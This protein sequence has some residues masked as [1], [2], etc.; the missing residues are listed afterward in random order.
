MRHCLR[1]LQQGRR[2]SALVSE[3][4]WQSECGLIVARDAVDS[5]LD[6]NKAEL[7]VL[8]VSVALQVLSDGHGLLNQMIQ[9]LRQSG[10][11]SCTVVEAYG[12][13][14]GEEVKSETR[15]K[16]GHTTGRA[17]SQHTLPMR[18]RIPIPPETRALTVLLQ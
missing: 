11:K 13:R 8:V 10:S 16:R 12:W 14:E 9:I 5:R 3:G 4:R 17:A 15:E 1:A 2:V 18:K 6:E 7:G